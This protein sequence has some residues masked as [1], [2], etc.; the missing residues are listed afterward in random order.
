[1]PAAKRVTLG[2]RWGTHRGGSDHVLLLRVWLEAP[3]ADESYS[4]GRG[5]GVAL[6]QL[7]S[8]GRL[9]WGSGEVEAP[10]M[11]QG[12]WARARPRAWN[13]THSGQ[14]HGGHVAPSTSGVL[15]VRGNT[16]ISAEI[17]SRHERPA[18]WRA[19]PAPP[20]GSRPQTLIRRRG[21]HAASMLGPP[22]L[23]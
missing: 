22:A 21:R 3:A 4:Q 5:R 9:S 19:L 10:R 8:I 11:K 18:P 17:R 20:G 13:D 12:S 16:E 14:S 15:S 6:G 23:E 2:G 1:M 7:V